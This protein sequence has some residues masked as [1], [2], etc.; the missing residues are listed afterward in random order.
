MKL[1]LSAFAWLANALSQRLAPRRRDPDPAEMGTAF[2]LD[3]TIT[4]IGPASSSRWPSA[5][6]APDSWEP[7][8]ERRSRR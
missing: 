5:S 8:P 4:L 1:F 6:Q 2:G 7:R 3:S